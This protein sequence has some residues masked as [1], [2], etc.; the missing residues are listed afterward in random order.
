[1]A[2]D[3][4]LLDLLRVSKKVKLLKVVG[5]HE[6]NVRQNEISE[7]MDIRGQEMPDAANI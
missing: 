1:L 4:Q 2:S 6:R 3:A 5:D 7:A